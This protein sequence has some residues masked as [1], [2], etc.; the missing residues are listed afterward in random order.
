MS[1][2][3]DFLSGL[4]D[5]EGFFPRWLSGTAWQPFNGWLMIAADLL[6]F[7]AYTSIPL[8]ILYFILKKKREMAFPKICWL[9]AAFIFACGVS[10]LLD[11]FMF[12]WPAY[13]LSTFVRFITGLISWAAVFAM[14]PV[15]PIVL[16]LKSPATLQ[17]EIEE[18]K[19]A[20]AELRNLNLNLERMVAERT[21][22]LNE[23]ARQLEMANQEL[24]SFSYSV[25]HD[26]KAP[27]RKIEQFSEMIMRNGTAEV[28][29]DLRLYLTR[30]AGNASEMRRL[31]EDILCFS[32]MANAELR[33]EPVDL[34]TM[35]QRIITDFQTQE[36][37]R[38]VELVI[39]NQLST[40]ADGVLLQT[41]LENLLGNA[42]KYTGKNEQSR[43]EFGCR[44][45][46]GQRIY[47]VKDDGVGFDM[48]RL[49]RLFKPFQ[50]LHLKDDFPG[51]G[52]GLASVQRII[53]RHGG[54]V[55]A[56]GCPGE[57]ATFYFTLNNGKPH[58]AEVFSS[59]LTDNL[60][61]PKTTG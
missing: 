39:G 21:Q 49:D 9:F 27:L 44:E 55:W 11:A 8:L 5:T 61:N 31:I 53:S 15:I 10:H 42:W 18:R 47:F 1:F 6:M 3:F 51:T 29:D 38:K 54:R 23:K 14:L 41:V 17:R 24:E 50:R 57:G 30:I 26:L 60:Y 22:E 2:V 37:E 4:L 59:S 16:A 43:I 52:I 46:A 40:E 25:S 20:E 34:G 58:E 45:E 33:M 28:S 48:G 35:A 56:E 32:K 36:P 13:R 7:G 19:K 12:W